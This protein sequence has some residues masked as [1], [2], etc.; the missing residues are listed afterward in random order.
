MEDICR[1][2]KDIRQ[3]DIAVVRG[4]SFLTNSSTTSG[5]IIYVYA[6]GNPIVIL[7]SAQAAK[8]LLENH[9]AN[10]ASRP[11]RTML[12]ELC[13][14]L[15]QAPPIRITDCFAAWVGSGCFLPYLTGTSGAST[16]LCFTNIS[17]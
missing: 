16:D 14:F 13:G 7:N 2:E 9:G 11:Y 17:T 15:S 8:D 6:F 12:L 1:V 4:I 3:V 5:D 10:Y